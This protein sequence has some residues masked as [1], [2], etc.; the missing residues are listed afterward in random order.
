MSIRRDSFPIAVVTL[1]PKRSAR[2]LVSAALLALPLIGCSSGSGSSPSTS[3]TQSSSA[4]DPGENGPAPTYVT[5]Q[6]Q[7]SGQVLSAD[8]QPLEDG[9]LTG[10]V[11]CSAAS[12]SR[13][14]AAVGSS[15]W[16]YAAPGWHLSAFTGA[17]VTPGNSLAGRL[18][19]YTIT[20]ATPNPLTVVFA[21]GAPDEDAGS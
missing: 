9:G 18:D 19:W 2:L 1:A 6:V 5:L 8:V 14:S 17:G 7:G 3:A 20:A 15:I 12:T 13:C 21:A 11:V 4:P 10:S 16:A